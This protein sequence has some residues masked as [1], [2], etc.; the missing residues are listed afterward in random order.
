MSLDSHKLVYHPER[1]NNWLEGKIIYPIYIEISLTSACNHRCK[2]CA[3]K[4][5]LDYKPLFMETDIIEDNIID[6]STHG[7]K[8]I[9]FGGEGEPLLHKDIGKISKLA[10][11]WG[12]DLA[13]T[14]NGVLFDKRKAEELLPLLTW[15]KFS[16][17]AGNGDIYANLH[18]TKELDYKT[19]LDN[20]SRSVYIRKLHDYK[21]K[22]GVQAILFESNIESIKELADSLRCIKPDYLVVKPYSPHNKTKDDNLIPPSKEQIVSL[23]TYM[24]DYKND[25]E[26]IYR[27]NAFCN[28]GENKP[29]DKCYGKDFMAYIDTLG[30]VYS[31]INFIGEPGFCYG[32]IH[33]NTF[34]KIWERKHE[35]NPDLNKCRSICRL[36]NINRYLWDL[37][38]PPSDNNFI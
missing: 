20:V 1:V 18:G 34:S 4:F 38:H 35:I 16:I 8:S 12:I 19:V 3:P 5:Y 31:C 23:I 17:D 24:Q 22:I 28:I 11:L 26:F 7:V 14:T 9:M 10:R 21:C 27:D 33:G 32:N 29:Y 30:G 2:F 36:D 37:K 25:F 6:M 15:I 13:L